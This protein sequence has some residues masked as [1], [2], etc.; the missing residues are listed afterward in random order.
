MNKSQIPSFLY[1]CGVSYHANGVINY[2]HNGKFYKVYDYYKTDIITQ[3]QIAAIAKE[4]PDLQVMGS[5]SQ[6]APEIKSV[7]VCIPKAALYKLKKQGVIVNLKGIV[8]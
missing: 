2:Q 5:R 6:Y 4:I 7:L 8:Q 1:R 3:D